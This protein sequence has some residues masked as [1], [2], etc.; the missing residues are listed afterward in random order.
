MVFMIFI[1]CEKDIDIPLPDNE[2]KLV[3]EG[4]IEQG[5]PPFVILTKSTGYFEPTDISSLQNLFVHDA[6]I[7]VSNGTVS[8]P[9]TEICTSQLPDSVLPTVAQLIGVSLY[10]LKTF[11]FCLYSTLDPSFY[12]EIGK[13]YSLNIQAEGKT[14]TSTTSIPQL[15]YADKFYYKDQPGYTDFGYLWFKLNDPPTLGNAYRIYTQRKNKDDRFIPANGS[16]FEDHFFNGLNFEAFIWRGIEQGSLDPNDLAETAK[17]FHQGDTIM[18]KFCS[19][20]QSHY[21]F[22]SSFEIASFNS[23]NPFAAPATIKTNIEGGGLGVWGG[24]AVTYDT[25]VAVD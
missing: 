20:D 16:V 8:V 12:G 5:L 7:I 13:T 25:I 14:L 1:S 3:V 11:G 24:Y 23:G 10:N 18:I 15:V 6:T 2:Q 19:I 17:Y 21:E 4:S 9:L 22:L